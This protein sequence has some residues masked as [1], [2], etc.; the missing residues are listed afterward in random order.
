ME[1]GDII[2]FIDN[3]Q[4]DGYAKAIKNIYHFRVFSIT[5]P[6][7]LVVVGQELAMGF[8]QDRLAAVRAAQ[9]YQI[10]HV[11]ITMNNLTFLQEFAEYSF[12][13]DFR[14]LDAGEPAPMHLPYSFKLGRNSRL[15]RNGGK[16]ISGVPEAAIENGRNLAAAYQPEIDAIET[17]LQ[18]PWNFEGED[19]GAVLSPVIIRRPANPGVPV[20]TFTTVVDA[21]FR[22][23]GSQNTRKQ[24]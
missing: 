3:Q 6:Q 16:R 22:G 7:D 13:T 18:S 19:F 2:E 23:F 8:M 17:V 11:S 10:N 1:Q 14:G 12:I 21:T 24:L 9:S 5:T 4:A 20:V 15:T